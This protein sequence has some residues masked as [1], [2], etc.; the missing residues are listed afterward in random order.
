MAPSF[1]SGSENGSQ[2]SIGMQPARGAAPFTSKRWRR[3][4]RES[5]LSNSI[6]DALT[7]LRQGRELTSVAAFIVPNVRCSAFVKQLIDLPPVDE[8]FL[9]AKALVLKVWSCQRNNITESIS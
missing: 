4:E 6:P 3:T 9:S 7:V 8:I 5:S 2:N 1:S